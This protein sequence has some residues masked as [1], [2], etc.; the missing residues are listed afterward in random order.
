MV[1]ILIILSLLSVFF[2]EY[3]TEYLE[4]KKSYKSIIEKRNADSRELI[5]SFSKNLKNKYPQDAN[6]QN[7]ANK[8]ITDYDINFKKNALSIREYNDVKRDLATQHSFRG[9]SSLHFWLATFGL[10][11]LGFYFSIKSLFDSFS[12]GSTFKHQLVDLAGIIVCSFWAIHLI[13]L[14]QNDF[15]ANRYIGTLLVCSILISGFVY[16]TV[17]YF[18][19]KDI[20]INKLT[21]LLIRT[22]ENHFERVAVKAY[23][24]EKNDKPIISLDTTK[25]NIES[26]D[27]DV[28]DTINQL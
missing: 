9:R 11:T 23:Y 25:E 15:L 13:F 6:I 3:S 12:R 28:E 24:A 7:L 2:D 21:N 17:R 4:H 1:L 8:L 22:K 20:A 5:Y 27:K 10:V 26:F 14:T 19:Y 16:F 18:N